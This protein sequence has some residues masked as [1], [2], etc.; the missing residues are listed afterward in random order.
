MIKREIVVANKSG[1]CARP[2]A[3]FVQ[4]TNK[5]TSDIFVEKGTQKINAKS[6]MGIMALGIGKDEKI[7]L[8][9]DGPDEEEAIKELVQ[10]VEKTLVDL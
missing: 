2:A 5:F 4:M 8:I 7:T 6:I 1:L 9:I 10:L 3:L